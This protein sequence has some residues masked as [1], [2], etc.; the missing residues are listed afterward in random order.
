GNFQSNAIN[1]SVFVPTAPLSAHSSHLNNQSVG[2]CGSKINVA[3]PAFTP[4]HSEFSFSS[5][6]PTFRPDAPAFTPLNS[7]FS[8]SLGS[9]NRG[10]EGPRTSIFS[11][12]D[13]SLA[14]VVKPSKKSKA[15]PIVRPDSNHSRSVEDET[16]EGK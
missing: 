13:L 15:I 10:N 6:G 7:K 3:A 9:G 11:N 5:S 14:S 4:G 16:M 2:G 8:D 1:H 12:I